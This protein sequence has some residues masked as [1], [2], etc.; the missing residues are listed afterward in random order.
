MSHQE[1]NLAPTSIPRPP[2]CPGCGAKMEL[3]KIDPNGSKYINLDLWSYQCEP[4]G[5]TA[6]NYVAHNIR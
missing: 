6:S 4:C 1:F 5:R 3:T 2:A